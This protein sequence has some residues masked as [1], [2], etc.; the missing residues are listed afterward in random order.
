MSSLASIS[1]CCTSKALLHV[2]QRKTQCSV[3][4]LYPS[5]AQTEEF[6]VQWDERP[7]GFLPRTQ[8]PSGAHVISCIIEQSTKSIRVHRAS[9]LTEIGTRRCEKRVPRTCGRRHQGTFSTW[10]VSCRTIL[11]RMSPIAYAQFGNACPEVTVNLSSCT[12]FA[13]CLQRVCLDVPYIDSGASSF[14]ASSTVRPR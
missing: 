14:D 5:H 1:S 6:V 10:G 7:D 8:R 11:L 12:L 9:A 4:L 3:F 2:S 13:P